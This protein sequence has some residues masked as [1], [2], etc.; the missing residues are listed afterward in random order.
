MQLA[1]AALADLGYD[2]MRN[3]PYAG[4]YITERYGRPASGVHVVQ[5]E[6]NRALYADE[7]AYA[8]T[9][10]FARVRSDLMRFVEGFAGAVEADLGHPLA[11]E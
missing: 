3:K 4:G 2:V 11:A 10:A 5:I 6:I 7:R 9:P 8:L 1:T